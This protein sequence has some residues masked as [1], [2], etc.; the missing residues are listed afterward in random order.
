MSR[1]HRR[2]VCRTDL[3][4]DSARTEKQIKDIQDK[5][6]KKKTEIIQVQS[7][8][9]AGAAAPSAVAVKG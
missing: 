9:Q 5:I 8:V 4:A 1:V 7:S 3:E 2:K 6:E